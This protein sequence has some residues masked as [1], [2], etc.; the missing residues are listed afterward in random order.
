MRT[1]PPDI[2]TR[3]D[4]C[5]SPNLKARFTVWAPESARDVWASAIRA[6]ASTASWAVDAA[7]AG[8]SADALRIDAADPDAAATDTSARWVCGVVDATAVG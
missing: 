5:A 4:N 6:M 8:A 7:V 1:S 3:T 2:S